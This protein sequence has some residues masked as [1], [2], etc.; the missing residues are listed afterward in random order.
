VF[1]SRWW[2]IVSTVYLFAAPIPILLG[3][4]NYSASALSNRALVAGGFLFLCVFGPLFFGL[5][6]ATVIE[7]RRKS[8]PPLPRNRLL[9][10]MLR[11]TFGFAAPFLASCIVFNALWKL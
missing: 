10:R 5:L 1:T 7:S 2:G 8:E 4:M 3:I 11:I 6:V 9:R